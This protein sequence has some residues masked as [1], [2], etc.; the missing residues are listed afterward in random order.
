M[1]TLGRVILAPAL[2][3][4]LIA[5]ATV[6]AGAATAGYPGWFNQ[7]YAPI[8]GGPF[9]GGALWG[10]GYYGQ[11]FYVN[12]SYRNPDSGV[13]WDNGQNLSTGTRGWTS[14]GNLTFS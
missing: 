9:P 10:Y 14:A 12:S 6:D 8:L 5:A 3:S 13:V 11:E 1:R 4:G 2:A 7:D